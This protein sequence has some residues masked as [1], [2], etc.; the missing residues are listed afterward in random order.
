MSFPASLDL[1]ALL[2][3]TPSITLLVTSRVALRVR[4]EHE[5]AL[6]PLPLPT[7]ADLAAAA[8][9][10]FLER[11]AALGVTLTGEDTATIVEICRLLD[12]LP[13]AI[14]L[15]AVRL[16]VLTPPML[17]ARL[18]DSLAVL[19]GGD[20]DRP[21]RH[22]SLRAT[23]D[24]SVGLLAT[25]AA[26]LL[27]TAG[28]FVG[29]FSLEQLG[30]IELG[31]PHA[32]PV[33]DRLQELVEAAL[34]HPAGPLWPGRFTTLQ[35]VRAYACELAG[36]GLDELRARHSAYFLGELSAAAR[37]L[38]GPAE[39]TVAHELDADLP[40][41]RQALAWAL[42]HGTDDDAAS[43][44]VASQSYFQARGLLPEAAAI[45]TQAC[46]HGLSAPVDLAATA[47][48]GRIAYY[49]DQVEEAHVLLDDALAR[50]RAARSAEWT[51]YCL[52]YFAPVRYLLD[53]P[54]IDGLADEA[55]QLARPVG[56]RVLRQALALA[57]FAASL[58]DDR[59]AMQ[60]LGAEGLAIAR[61][62]GDARLV[63]YHL[64][65]VVDLAIAEGRFDEARVAARESLD[66]ARTIG[67]TAR[68]LDALVY[69]ALTAL[70]TADPKTALLYG[71]EA[72]AM[73]EAVE[74]PATV[75][76]CLRVLGAAAILHGDL[77]GGVRLF[78]AAEPL[79]MAGSADERVLHVVGRLLDGARAQL[80]PQRFERLL[81]EGRTA[82]RAGLVA[83]ALAGAAGA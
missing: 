32:R 59:E 4:G 26:Q 70:W 51:V 30:A 10:L 33:L 64:L 50:A 67:D 7:G 42:T 5:V 61:E 41:L 28:V 34:V 75:G 18:E 25:D 1:A 24:W 69:V 43:A 77:P 40:D 46:R 11:A 73:A 17:L 49:L 14:E 29:R 2:G 65:D 44:V 55:V 48:R 63:S 22:R 60:Q 12:G 72:L 82:E 39:L 76:R 16:R 83:A 38:D 9:Q 35:T 3:A 37:G 36:D 66:V 45:L 79:S 20:R 13:L 21:D 23:L 47:T 19:T 8:G 54:E 68:E 56:G 57:A 52:T 81:D 53:D 74:L 27:A 6:A 62:L 31:D 15:A 58:R 71:Q 78:G 80:P